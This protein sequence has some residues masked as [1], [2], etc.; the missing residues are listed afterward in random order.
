MAMSVWANGTGAVRAKCTGP[1]PGRS[2]LRSCVKVEVAVLGS[3]PKYA[4]GFCGCKA[5][6]QQQQPGRYRLVRACKGN[7]GTKW[8]GGCTGKTVR[9]NTGAVPVHKGK[10]VWGQYGLRYG[11]LCGS[12]T[13]PARFPMCSPNRKYTGP[14]RVPVLPIVGS[15]GTAR[16]VPSMCPYR[17]RTG[18]FTGS[19][20][21]VLCATW[22]LS[23]PWVFAVTM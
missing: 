5:T 15:V 8:Y 6:L 14:L 9:G 19:L 2:E 16:T 1:V 23:L 17:P 7:T 21:L 4:Y 10:T 3:R 22:I 20:A 12:G 13:G 18:M 11:A